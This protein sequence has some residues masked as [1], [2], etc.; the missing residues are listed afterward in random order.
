MKEMTQVF[1]G[2]TPSDQRRFITG[3]LEYLR[4]QLTRVVIPCCGQFTLAR[5]AIEAGYKADELETS[6]ISLFSSVLG[7]LYAEKPLDDL[8]FEIEG[9]YAD[10]YAKQKS[11]VEKAAYLIWLMK[12]LQLREELI[13]ENMVRQEYIDRQDH[14][15]AQL[16]ETLDS[17]R[18]QYEGLEYEVKDLRPYMFEERP[19]SE[20]VLVNPPA[21]AKG[22]EKMFAPIAE[23]IK[24]DPAVEEFD[25]AGEYENLYEESKKQPQPFA[26]Y[27]YKDSSMFPDEEVVFGRE[28]STER[29]DFWLF[30]K[31][32]LLKDWKYN[33]VLALKKGNEYKPYH[34]PV[35]GEDDALKADS[36][37]QFV[38]VPAEVGLYY[39]DLWAHKLG[40][41]KAEQY[42]LM[43]IDGKV[44]GTIGLM[45]NHLFNLSSNRVFENFGFNAP[46]TDHPRA[47]RLLMMAITC[48]EF[49]DVLRAT[50]SK[51]NRVYDLAGLRT[52]CLAKYRKVKL[53]NGILDLEVREKLPNGMYR[54]V[55]DTDFRQETFS[56]C[57][58]RYLAEEEEH[59]KKAKEKVVA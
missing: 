19:E 6:D 32:K 8:G 28:Y 43:L 23:V 46:M 41:T 34:A 10:G 50:A 16:A 13:Y 5:C 58:E 11:E 54:L 39:R 29:V 17:M 47:N 33:K 36:K 15:L 14:H 31:P 4:P 35:W 18:G 53:N 3:V 40:A 45:T 30:T 42:Y 49:A 48:Q 37:I 27:R 9:K 7:Y 26:W 57:I 55:Y 22:Y 59:A 21:F 12:I 24:F 2:N 44:F 25:F 56:D 20:I 51:V 38:S 1:L 52:T